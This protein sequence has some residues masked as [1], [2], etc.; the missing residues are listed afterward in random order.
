MRE[1]QR[2]KRE[3]FG[4]SILNRGDRSFLEPFGPVGV[5]LLVLLEGLVV[6]FIDEALSLA[7]PYCD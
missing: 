3:S 2:E 1:F 5:L 6:S 7:D 4:Q